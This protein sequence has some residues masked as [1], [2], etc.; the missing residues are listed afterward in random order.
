MKLF[1]KKHMCYLSWK[2]CDSNNLKYLIKELVYSINYCNVDLLA[3]VKARSSTLQYVVKSVY[4][5]IR[6][7]RINNLKIKSMLQTYLVTILSLNSN[8]RRILSY[9]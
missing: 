7:L 6:Y 8:Y 4:S 1:D 9:T 3:L 5:F 2:F